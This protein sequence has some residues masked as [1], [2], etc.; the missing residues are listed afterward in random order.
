MKQEYLLFISLI[1]LSCNS[2]EKKIEVDQS[3][4][5]DLAELETN[6][7]FKI[8]YGNGEIT[9]AKK[10][11]ALIDEAYLFLSEIMG[12][13]KDFCLLVIAG[14][15]WDKNAYSPITG[16]PEY[17]K[18]NLIVGAGQN[19]MASGYE[20]LIRS[21]PEVLTSDLIKTY[22]NDAEAF[23]MRLF[24]D[25]L[26]IHELTH[27]FQDPKNQEGYS[28]SR[29]LEEVH[30]NMGLY[31]FYKTKRPKEL[32][33]INTLVDFS[34]ENSTPSIKYQSLSDFDKHYFDMDPGNYGFYQMKFTG[35]ARMLIDSLGNDILKPLNDFLIKYDES[36]K[37]KMTEE[38]FK[39]KLTNEVDPY[40]VEIFNNWTY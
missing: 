14:K 33:Y 37:E 15:D 24:F 25:K 13:K 6:H 11:T 10:Q 19:D 21:F 39:K 23:D 26:S 34:I 4:H 8:L 30:A 1:V 40:F 7:P 36:W 16:M 17:Y 3:K 32:K 18:G 5:I 31:A 38:D 2:L 20:E 27:N 9:Y 35:A 28:M 12:P 22:T 29:W